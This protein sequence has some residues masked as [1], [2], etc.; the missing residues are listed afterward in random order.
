MKK[1]IIILGAVVL[2]VVLAW[3]AAWLVLAGLVRQN[4]EAQAL[5]DGVTS[6]R[7]A[8]GTLDI[9]GFPFRFDVDCT[10]ARIESGDLVTEIPGLRASIMVYRPT[11]LLAS[12]LG[13]ASITDAFTG[14]R[15]TLAWSSLEGSIRLDNWRIARLSIVGKDLVWSDTLLGNTVLAQ[16]PLVET[17][18]LDIPEQYDAERHVAALAGYFHA[19]NLAYPGMTLT[20]TNGEV[21]FEL[22][23]LPDDIRN[24]GDPLLPTVWQQSGGQLKIV[25]VRGSDGTSTLNAQGELKLDD[26]GQVEGQIGIT[27]TGVAER[28]GP[29]LAEPWRTLVLGTPAADGSYANQLNFRA[30]AVYSGLVPIASIPPLY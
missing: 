16:S 19:Q 26:A 13:P 9:G 23:G 28:I 1:R 14:L 24:W 7:L 12:A 18:L 15:N 30:G 2:F 5:A 17:H 27:S 21:E 6:P 10:Q 20:D 22:T 8:C 4:I 25:S 29:L 11:H 3:S